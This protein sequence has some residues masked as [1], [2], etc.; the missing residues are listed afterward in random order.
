MY[1]HSMVVIALKVIFCLRAVSVVLQ[2]IFHSC[3]SAPKTRYFWQSGCHGDKDT[4]STTDTLQLLI[5]A[6]LQYQWYSV[7]VA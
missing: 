2:T 4:P 1:P 5:F 7:Q 6:S 3:M